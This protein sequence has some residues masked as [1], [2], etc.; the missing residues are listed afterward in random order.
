VTTW[1]ENGRIAV[2]GSDSGAGVPK[3]LRDQIFEAFFT[4]LDRGKGTGLGLPFARAMIAR[5]GERRGRSGFV[6]E[7]PA[8]TL[9]E[10]RTSRYAGDRS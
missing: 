10:P 1:Q 6:L 8:E 2:E 7:L 3:Q 4:T 5:H 9:A